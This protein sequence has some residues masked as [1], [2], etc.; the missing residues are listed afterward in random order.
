MQS[1]EGLTKHKNLIFVH[2]LTILAMKTLA[3]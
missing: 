2:L 3:K 1:S